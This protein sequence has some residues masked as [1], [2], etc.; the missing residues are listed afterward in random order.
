MSSFGCRRLA[1]MKTASSIYYSALPNGKHVN[2]SKVLLP[3]LSGFVT[4][5]R[6]L[7]LDSKKLIPFRGRKKTSLSAYGFRMQESSL[8][9]RS[10]SSALNSITA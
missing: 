7:G 4:L 2:N 8:T 10:R 1:W 3:A 6:S 5:Q 9:A